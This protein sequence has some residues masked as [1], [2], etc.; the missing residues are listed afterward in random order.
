MAKIDSR[1]VRTFDERR[2]RK[3]SVATIA[4]E[5]SSTSSVTTLSENKVIHGRVEKIVVHAPDL[6]TDT[7][8]SFYIDA[9]DGTFSHFS[10]TGVSDAGNTVWNLND[11]SVGAPFLLAGEV[12]IRFAWTTAQTIASS[13]PFQYIIY[14]R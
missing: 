10:K 14:V 1:S 12:R 9:P 2:E 6:T 3:F 4:G 5:L 8:F 7:T 13:D 11:S